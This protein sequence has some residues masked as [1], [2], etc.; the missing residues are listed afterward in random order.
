MPCV[1]LRVRA[2]SATRAEMIPFPSLSLRACHVCVLGDPFLRLCGFPP[3]YDENTSV[4][5]SHIKAGDYDFPSP[6][7]DE[8]SP[9]GTW[10]AL[11]DRGHGW[12][13]DAVRWQ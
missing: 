5:F 7:W 12:E 6:E 10:H 2:V 4:M 8:V 3:F 11:C 13:V 1:Q 9:D